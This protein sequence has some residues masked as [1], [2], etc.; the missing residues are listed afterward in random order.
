MGRSP[1]GAPTPVAA[2]QAAAERQAAHSLSAAL[3]RPR[4]ARAAPP[5]TP[6]ARAPGGA[7]KM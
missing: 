6:G 7:L 5:R 4:H 1:G 2:W 3:A